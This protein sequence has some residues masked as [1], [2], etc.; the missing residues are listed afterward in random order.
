[1]SIDYSC[2]GAR[3][4]DPAKVFRSFDENRLQPVVASD[5]SKEPLKDSITNRNYNE[6]AQ[7]E[8]G[9]PKPPRSAFMC[10]TDRRKEEIMSQGGISK[11]R[12][13]G[14]LLTTDSM[15]VL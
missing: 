2:C 14:S 4:S 7:N 5:I 8:K 6:I 3:H 1:L 11:V 9:P 13:D 15:F 10:F 12:C